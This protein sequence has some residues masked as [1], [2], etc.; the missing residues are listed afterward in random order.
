M[1]RPLP[2]TQE[3]LRIL[4]A[5][6]SRPPRA[7]PPPAARALVKT[8]KALDDKFGRGADGLKVRWK[9][10]VG[11]TLARRSE[12]SKL[13]KPRNGEGAVL[14]LR[15]EGPSAIIIQHQSADILARVNL[16]L[17]TGAVARL[18]VVQGPLHGLTERPNPA[19]R[20]ARRRNRGPLDAAAEQGLLDSL[21]NF[22]EGVLK[23]ALIRLGREVIRHD[24]PMP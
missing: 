22:P 10:I 4:T 24:R 23:D 20:A 13:I 18:R 5:K 17:G 8:L 11:Q 1:A 6:R 21:A 15:V 16:F 14:E 7:P 2:S 19:M 12:P 3:A 9:E